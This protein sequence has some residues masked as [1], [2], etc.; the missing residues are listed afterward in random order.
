MILMKFCGIIAG[1]CTTGALVP[2][3][4]RS[5][6]RSATEIAIGVLEAYSVGVVLVGGGLVPA[7]GR[8]PG[9]CSVARAAGRGRG[10]GACPSEA[11]R[12][13]PSRTD[14]AHAA[15]GVSARGVRR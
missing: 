10:T 6:L 5:K 14:P 15:D 1:I 9:V 4:Y 12:T 3:V 8:R 13:N 11:Q 7:P 2:Q